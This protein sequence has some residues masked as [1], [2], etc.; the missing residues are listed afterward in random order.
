MQVQIKAMF[1]GDIHEETTVTE[2]KL[3]PDWR[4]TWTAVRCWSACERWR[5]SSEGGEKPLFLFA[6]FR[7][8]IVSML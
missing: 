8:F 1:A 6:E 4:R 7:Y 5:R 3:R 2:K